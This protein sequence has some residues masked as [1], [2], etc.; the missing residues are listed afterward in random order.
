MPISYSEIKYLNDT[1][2]I[3][4]SNF[5]WIFWDIKHHRPLLDNVSDYWINEVAGKNVYKIF[6]G[7]GYGIWTPKFGTIINSTF[8][9]ISI[10]TKDEEVI[11]VA[12]KWVDEADLVIML[13][14]DKQGELI[15]KEVLSTAEYDDLT[16]N[17]IHE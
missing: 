3:L 15:R 12:E 13:Y 11:Y 6:K 7:I 5:R 16:C 1:V 8:S 4:N 17:T 14:Y 10:V 9:E 2:A